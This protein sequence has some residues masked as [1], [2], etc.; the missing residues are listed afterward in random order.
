LCPFS[1]DFARVT[2]VRFVTHNEF[3]FTRLKQVSQ[4]WQ[5]PRKLGDLKGVGHFGAKF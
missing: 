1:I 4:L 5:R 3:E 2:C